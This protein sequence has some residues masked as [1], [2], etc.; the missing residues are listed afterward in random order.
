MP[1]IIAV[2]GTPCCTRPST[3]AFRSAVEKLFAS[4]VVPSTPRPLQPFAS[5]HFACAAMR[6]RSGEKSGFIAVSTA[7]LM[8]PNRAS[9]MRAFLW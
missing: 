7:A 3:I 9:F 2:A 8:P 4:P 5:S 1:G 6:S